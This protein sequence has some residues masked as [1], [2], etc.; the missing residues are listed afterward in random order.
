MDKLPCHSGKKKFLVV[1]IINI[2]SVFS[3]FLRKI[4]WYRCKSNCKFG[5]KIILDRLILNLLVFKALHFFI[6]EGEDH[7]K[8][9]FYKKFFTVLFSQINPKCITQPKINSLI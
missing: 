3:Y 7:L 8:I 4:F 2:K 9:Y 5:G 1:I 6:S